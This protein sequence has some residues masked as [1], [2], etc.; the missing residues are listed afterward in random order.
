MRVL[1]LFSSA[2]GLCNYA[3]AK[4]DLLQD[5]MLYLQTC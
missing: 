1:V 3:N 4:L 2:V 5:A